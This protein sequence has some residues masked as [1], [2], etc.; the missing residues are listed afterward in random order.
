MNYITY[1]NKERI[2]EKAKSNP[3]PNILKL[4]MA[5]FASTYYYSKISGFKR[6]SQFLVYK[7]SKTSQR[8]LFC[9]EVQENEF[10]Y[11]QVHR[12]FS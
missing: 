2:Y 4:K 1:T 6:H 12:L 11:E 7:K 8:V 10:M 3:T 9:T 5:T